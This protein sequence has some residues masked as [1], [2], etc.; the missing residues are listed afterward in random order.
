MATSEDYDGKVTEEQINELEKRRIAFATALEKGTAD[1]D[2]A[3]EHYQTLA[4]ELLIDLSGKLDPSISDKPLPPADKEPPKP[5]E[6]TV[7]EGGGWGANPDADTWKT[8]QMKNPPTKWKVVDD[9]GKNV[10][11]DFTTEPNAQGYIDYYVW[12]KH[13]A[14][15]PPSPPPGNGK[16]PAGDN[17]QFGVVMIYATAPNGKVETNF[18]LQEKMRNYASGKPSEW[19]TEYTNVS[20]NTIQNQEVTLYVKINSFKKEPDTLSL[21]KGGP[22][23]QDGARFWICSDFATD[24]NPKRTL[25]IEDPHPKNRSIN[26][27]PLTEIG[28]SII[29]AWFGYKGISYQNKDGT[30]HVES[31]IHYPVANIDKIA[32]EQDKWRKYMVYTADKK[33]LT[34]PGKL[35]TSRLDGVKKGDPP[36]YKYASVRE[37]VSPG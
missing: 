6:G 25:E 15:P 13:Y 4:A 19:S 20:P 17:D 31:W 26:P 12:Q 3:R 11:T 28:G 33:Y 37:I 24:G 21:K 18:K 22:P 23:H 30:R 29:G 34:F 36:V 10:A 9:S 27:K 16:P 8:A 32:D 2:E 7:K 14:A 1:L 35:T 5:T